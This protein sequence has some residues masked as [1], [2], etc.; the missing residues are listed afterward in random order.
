MS[1]RLLVVEDDGS[2]VVFLKRAFQKIGFEH[3]VDVAGT[4]SEAITRLAVDGGQP[5]P[6][7]VLLDL[8]LPEKS[9]FEVLEWIRSQAGLSGLHVAI[10]TSSSESNDLRRAHELQAEC[11]LVKPIAFNVLVDLVRSIDRWIRSGEIPDIQQA[12]SYRP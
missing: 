5:A 3:P 12:R 11:Y 10:L 9:G 8:K 4:G 7:H 1:P 2:D 6:T